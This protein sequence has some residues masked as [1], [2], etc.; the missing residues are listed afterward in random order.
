MRIM[1]R[2]YLD[3]LRS[4]LQGFYERTQPLASVGRQLS[5]M[6]EDLQPAWEAGTLPGWE[7][8]GLGR[9]LEDGAQV[10]GGWKGG[11]PARAAISVL[12]GSMSVVLLDSH[13]GTPSTTHQWSV[14]PFWPPPCPLT[15]S[16][17]SCLRLGCH[18]VHAVI[19]GHQLWLLCW[20]GPA[21][22]LQAAAV[23]LDVFESLEELET[24]GADRLKEALQVWERTTAH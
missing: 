15:R 6:A 7:D 4:Y 23:D 18:A 10:S 21:C 3:Q 2:E 24:L 12:E 5:K 1:A 13:G 11:P 17:V 22:V 16:V 14:R 9:V 20:G 19:D 8:K